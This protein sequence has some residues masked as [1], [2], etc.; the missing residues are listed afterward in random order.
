MYLFICQSLFCFLLF[1][2]KILSST[3][4]IQQN[5][6]P[7]NNKNQQKPLLNDKISRSIASLIKNRERAAAFSWFLLLLSQNGNIPYCKFAEH[8]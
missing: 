3:L 5:N 1:L 7:R 4:K 8:K 2:N 6:N